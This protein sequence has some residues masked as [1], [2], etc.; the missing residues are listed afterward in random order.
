MI[1]NLRGMCEKTPQPYLIDYSQHHLE[2]HCYS[3]FPLNLFL[4]L[5]VG[6]TAGCD[7]Q[8]CPHIP[9][10]ETLLEHEEWNVIH[11]F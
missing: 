1:T 4:K 5:P 11:L 10:R 6:G 8:D 3:L 9:A 7:S 2:S